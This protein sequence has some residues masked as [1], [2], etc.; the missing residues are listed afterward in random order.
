MTR[1]TVKQLT[2]NW[3]MGTAEYAGKRL[4]WFGSC[5]LQVASRGIRDLEW[6]HFMA[7][8]MAKVA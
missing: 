4:A 6:R 3:Y 7:S 1:V 5:A 8:A 2:P